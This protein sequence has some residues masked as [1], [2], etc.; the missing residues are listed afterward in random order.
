M[1]LG[2]KEDWP[3]FFSSML[4]R[5]VHIHTFTNSIDY[6][7]WWL[8]TCGVD[9]AFVTSLV[10][11]R[12]L[13]SVFVFCLHIKFSNHGKIY[14][15][16]DTAQITTLISVEKT[17]CVLWLNLHYACYLFV[18]HCFDWESVC[19]KNNFS[20]AAP[21]KSILY[22]V[23]ISAFFIIK[24]DAMTGCLYLFIY[25]KSVSEK[26]HWNA[27]LRFSLHESIKL[28]FSEVDWMNVWNEYRRKI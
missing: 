18:K 16:I 1:W 7:Y 4:G 19:K 9:H 21:F 20:E 28:E 3:N 26:V 24:M 14:F 2:I 27:K 6:L 25:L 8:N 23:L 10:Y 12:F 22:S 5:K 11:A 13:F 15:F 17:V